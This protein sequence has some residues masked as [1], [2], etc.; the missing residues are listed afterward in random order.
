MTATI[1]VMLTQAALMA[2][3]SDMNQDKPLE[4]HQIEVQ[5]VERTNRQRQQFGLPAL[6]MDD[7]LVK[8]AR[9]HTT[10]MTNNETLQHTTQAVG[11]NIAMG[12]NSS[13]EVVQA[14][15]D[16]PGHRANILNSGYQRIGVAAYISKSGAIYWCQQFLQ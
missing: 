5:I 9:R 14:W 10:W 3:P 15:M 6:A 13:A 11:E 8:S 2:S 4:L 7:W 1:A 12:Q 16:S